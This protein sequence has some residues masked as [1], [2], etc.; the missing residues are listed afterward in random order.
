[1]NAFSLLSVF[2]NKMKKK[3]LFSIKMQQHRCAM[4]RELDVKSGVLF[5]LINM[6]YN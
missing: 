1:M 4:E 2:Q 6:L 5:N 3:Q